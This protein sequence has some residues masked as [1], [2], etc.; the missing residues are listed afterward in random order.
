MAAHENPQIR[1]ALSTLRAAEIDVQITREAFLPTLSLDLVYGI[2]ANA[3]QLRS[4]YVANPEKG[5]VPTL[6]YSL[7]AVLTVTVWDWAARK[8]KARQVEFR[9]EQARVELSATQRELIK[10][11]QAAYHEAEAARDQRDL[12]RQ[13]S[14]L[15]SESLRLNNLRYQAGEA[16][17]LEIVDAE[18]SLIQARNGLVDG[19]VRYRVAIA[20]L[21][22]LTGHFRLHRVCGQNCI[23]FDDG[24]ELKALLKMSAA[25]VFEAFQPT[26]RINR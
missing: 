6:G 11:L 13:V 16:T 20:N 14:D 4:T 15:A 7:D 1:A 25:D 12:L 26:Y 22:A 18:N 17:V 9:R 2:E 8:S 23:S 3:I 19:E 10:N 5:P 24:Q 21:Q